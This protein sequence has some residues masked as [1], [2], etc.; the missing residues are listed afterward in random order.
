M[1][2]IG[3]KITE[4]KGILQISR[5]V[6]RFA[7]VYREGAVALSALGKTLLPVIDAM[8][9]WGTGHYNLRFPRARG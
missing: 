2:P 1:L 6:V 7:F 5:F 8:L 9:A 3:N 4:S